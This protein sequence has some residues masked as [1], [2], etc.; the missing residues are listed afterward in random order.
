MTPDRLPSA[1]ARSLP[2]R[3]EDLDAEHAAHGRG[4]ARFLTLR[5]FDD[6]AAVRAAL[7]EV[8]AAE[9]RRVSSSAI[10]CRRVPSS[11]IGC[12]DRRYPTASCGAPTWARP[13]LCSR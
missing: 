10:E 7:K 12:L 5:E 2:V 8:N 4:A 11:A 6:V 3:A 13:P 9:C 1:L